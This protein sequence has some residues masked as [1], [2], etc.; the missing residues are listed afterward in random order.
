M[1]F[2]YFA[3]I[4]CF[5]LFAVGRSEA[6]EEHNDLDLVPMSKTAPEIQVD[7][8]L[9]RT[10][11]PFKKKFYREN[12]AYIRYGTLQKLRAVQTDLSKRG[13]TLR[14]WSAYRPFAV[15]VEMFHLAG[16]NGNWVSDPYRSSGKKTHV[17]AVAVDCTLVDSEGRELAMPTPYL[18]FEHGAEKMKHSY[19]QLSKEVL[20]NRKLLK[21]TMM[22]HGMEP[23][24]GEWWHYQ[25][26]DWSK[27]PIIE[28]DDFREIHRE[29]L[30][31]DVYQKFLDLS[32]K[33]KN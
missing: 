16:G 24:S 2:R 14:I 18:D 13:F 4:I 1:N 26:S 31:P 8:R 33:S 27:Y 19:N 5:I 25:D 28:F 12:E 10:D 29:M 21:D 15:Q 23:Y 22:A 17:R 30:E 3:L 7:L 6:V 20:A 32:K 9:F 11:H